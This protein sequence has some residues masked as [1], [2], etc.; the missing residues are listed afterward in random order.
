[1]SRWHEMLQQRGGGGMKNYVPP[2]PEEPQG[3][4]VAPT[5]LFHKQKITNN[6]RTILKGSV[7]KKFKKQMQNLFK[8]VSGVQWKQLFPSKAV[9]LSE[10]LHTSVTSRDGKQTNDVKMLLYYIKP[11]S[12]KNASAGKKEESSDD[13][14]DD[15]EE[16]K[17]ED[18]KEDLPT[19]FQLLGPGKADVGHPIFIDFSG[20]KTDAHMMYPT[21]YALRVIPHM[22]RPMFIY[23]P[24]SEYVISGADV[25][26]PGVII[27][28][29]GIGKFTRGDKRA[30][31]VAGNPV[32]IG[33]G[34]LLSDSIQ[35]EN[36]DRRGKALTLVHCYNDDLWDFG[37]RN[38]PNE[39]FFSSYVDPIIVPQKEETAAAES[40]ADRTEQETDDLAAAILGT[41]ST[42]TEPV[43][44]SSAETTIEGSADN[45]ST[46]DNKTEVATESQDESVNQENEDEEDEEEDE[47]GEE[48]EDE[49][50]EAAAGDA[51]DEDSKQPA[52][53]KEKMD[54]S[55]RRALYYAIK[56][57]IQ[58]DDL[59]MEP[60]VLF[61]AHMEACNIED[62]KLDV[63]KSSYKK[64]TK[65][66]KDMQKAKILQVKTC[67]CKDLNVT[68]V[69]HSHPSIR[70][71]ILDAKY[72]N[73][74]KQK[75]KQREKAHEKAEEA[76]AA[77]LAQLD[78][79]SPAQ[80]KHDL[81][82]LHMFKPDSTLKN[83]LFS[84]AHSSQMFTMADAKS[85]LWDYV[86]KQNLDMG[87]KVQ[88]DELLIQSFYS[89]VRNSENIGSVTKAD[90]SKRLDSH[91]V[92]YHAIVTDGDVEHA[93]FVKGPVPYVEV[94]LE[95]R[96]GNKFMTKIR[97][98]EVF[99]IDLNQFVKDCQKT[100]SC[101][102]TLANLTGKQSKFKEVL[103][104]GNVAKEVPGRIL[105][106]YGISPTL[107]KVI[108]PTTG[109]KGGAGKGK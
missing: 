66:L 69:N 65:F 84:E 19:I 71:M 74:V 55:L 2:E 63:K 103:I 42:S 15:K 68:S 106:S 58:D 39:G 85:V 93:K 11:A 98:L 81:I 87:P 14:D 8:G 26:W 32:P 95:Q 44:Q 17:K 12:T 40:S 73:I 52:I 9:F 41:D 107:A 61:S 16:D 54:E 90:I 59:P 10:K 35:V 60:T 76:I 24:V 101:S 104:Q 92:E 108:S 49:D 100:F 57:R 97:G 13:E 7:M 91:M 4:P 50:D 82:I 1:M 86:K 99:G 43:E 18:K 46:S 53:P 109:S 105:D 36:N 33:V 37:D 51:K 28:A 83:S 21:I 30:L 67:G 94:H 3:P 62:F 23:P 34:W 31:F 27:P 77:K 48:D 29:E 38:P 102:A 70:G 80:H 96:Q 79:A 89:E 88:L 72:L 25:M 78:M 64:L 20:G 22:M 6:G 75:Q 47:D 56:T 5:G 45:V